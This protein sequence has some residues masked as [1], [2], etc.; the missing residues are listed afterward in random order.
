MSASS[1]PFATRGPVL[2][3]GSGL[4]GAS[5]GLAL[6]AGGVEVMLRDT[7]P[8]ALRLA[9]D[10]GAGTPFAEAASADPRLVVVA[11][12][13]DVADLCVV[14]ALKE[15]PGAVVTDVASVKSAV[16]EGVLAAAADDPAL[17]RRYVGS[18]PMAGR[19]RS[20]AGGADAD[21][22][23]G[24]P[25]VVVAHPDTDAA[26][27]LAARTLATDV[28]S[29]PIEMDAA[30]HD[31]SVAL[32]SHVPQLLSS[33]LA[34]RLVEARGESLGLAGQGLRDTTRIAASDPRL[35]TAILA[36]NAGPVVEVLEHVRDDLDDLLVHLH[37]AAERGPLRGGSVGAVNRVMQAGNAGVARIPGKHGGA[38]RRYAELEVLIPDEPGEL[39]RLFTEL[40]EIDV[41]IEDLVLEHS[42]G[43]AVGLARL[44]VDPSRIAAAETELERRGWRLITHAL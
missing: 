4:L 34:A 2:I 3:I 8:T 31:E 40:G 24:R 21:L 33:L 44:C 42:G 10:I 18:H 32:V 39:G 26:A 5:L 29:V 23:Y 1:R 9:Q 12:P 25:W 11:A 41:N 16:V 28:G 7:S 17:A 13:P 14:E 15:F 36:G 27:V 43:L 6:R 22:F 38:P 35:W 30:T 19:E 20:G 37:A